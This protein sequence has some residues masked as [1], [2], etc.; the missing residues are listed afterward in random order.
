M[1]LWV[2]FAVWLRVA[3]FAFLRPGE[4]CG[5]LRICISLPQAFL[6]LADD[7]NQ[8]AV[9][10]AMLPKHWRYVGG[11]QLAY[12]DGD[13]T[14]EWLARLTEELLDLASVFPSLHQMRLL[15]AIALHALHLYF[16]LRHCERA[17]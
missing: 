14:I 15:L 5:P 9:L 8:R 4:L 3:F 7:E 11:H 1:Y 13:A 6:A 16:E 17:Q 2:R 10:V 12:L